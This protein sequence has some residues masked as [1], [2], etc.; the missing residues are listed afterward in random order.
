LFDDINLFLPEIISVDVA[1]CRMDRFGEGK[2]KQAVFVLY[3]GIHYDA[4][5]LTPSLGS[6]QEFDQT[7]FEITDPHF[8][9]Y[10]AA[11]VKLAGEWKKKKKFTDLANFTLKCSICQTVR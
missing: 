4:L 10:I 6:S 7:S 11:A 8:S 9:E 1:T 2:H 3:T 5:A